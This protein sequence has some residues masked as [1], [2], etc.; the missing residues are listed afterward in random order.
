LAGQA[1]NGDRDGYSERLLRRLEKDA[2][3][4]AFHDAPELS[5]KFVS[6]L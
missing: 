2:M 6:H 4:R 1:A 3:I 5:E